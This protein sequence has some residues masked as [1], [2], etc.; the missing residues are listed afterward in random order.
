MTN[1]PI[2]EIVKVRNHHSD[3]PLYIDF[4]SSNQTIEVEKPVKPASKPADP[5]F[6]NALRPRRM[7]IGLRYPGD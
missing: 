1:A 6:K 4:T 7:R 3:L 5:A 2:I